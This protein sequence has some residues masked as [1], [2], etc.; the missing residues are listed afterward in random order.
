[1]RIFTRITLAFIM[2]LAITTM[3]EAGTKTF[4]N[5][6]SQTVTVTIEHSQGSTPA[7]IPSSQS[8]TIIYSPQNASR[9]Y[10]DYLDGTRREWPQHRIN[11]YSKFI[12]KNSAI[13]DSN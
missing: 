12:I 7:T 5:D 13:Y 9:I 6:S 4:I 8:T 1:M 11:N 3:A 10:V 2:S